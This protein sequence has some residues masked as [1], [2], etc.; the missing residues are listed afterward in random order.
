[1]SNRLKAAKSGSGSS[2]GPAATAS[3]AASATPSSGGGKPG[4]KKNQTPIIIISPSSTSPITMYNV[5]KFLEAGEY[6]TMDEARLE[7]NG[8]GAGAGGTTGGS[9]KFTQPEDMQVITHWRTVGA[10]NDKRSMRFHVIDSIETLARLGAG[11]L[12]EAW[13]VL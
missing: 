3:S 1:M 2:S 4:K 5:K 12:D 13:C 6:Q 8:G 11:D 7:L 9:N 10:G